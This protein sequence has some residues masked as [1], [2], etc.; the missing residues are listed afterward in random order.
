[1][2]RKWIMGLVISLVTYSTVITSSPMCDKTRYKIT[3]R[4]CKLVIRDL[5]SNERAGVE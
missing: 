4:N 3:N 1:M 5:H 2:V